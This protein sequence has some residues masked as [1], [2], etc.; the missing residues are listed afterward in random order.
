MPRTKT[1][2]LPIKDESSRE[3]ALRRHI[4]MISKKAIEMSIMTNSNYVIWIDPGDTGA[5]VY[6]STNSE[7]TLKKFKT[8]NMTTPSLSSSP[9]EKKESSSKGKYICI[10]GQYVLYDKY[11]RRMKNTNKYVELLMQSESKIYEDKKEDIQKFIN[12][13]RDKMEDD[14]GNLI[15]FLLLYI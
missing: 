3:H 12:E 7:K 8:D 15:F 4:A 2:L 14:E 13:E 9:H 1:V 10:C 11:F 6:I 5:P